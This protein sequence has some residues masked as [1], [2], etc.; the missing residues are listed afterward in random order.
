MGSNGE[1]TL[2]PAALEAFAAAI[3]SDRV[4]TSDEDIP[5]FRDP[6]WLATTR[7]TTR[8]RSS[9]RRRPRRSRRS[10]G[11]PTSTA[12]RSGRTRP[13]ATTATAGPRRASAAASSSRLRNMNRVL[14]IDDDLAYAVVEP[15]VRWFDLYDALQDGGH[16]L[17]V[18]IPDL[19]LGQRGR[20]LARQRRHLPEP[21]PGLP[22]GLRHGGRP[23]RRHRSCA[24]AWA[25]M[26]GNPAWHTYKRGLGPVLDPLF[27]QSNYGIVTRMGVW[28]QRRPEC[29]LPCRVPAV[30]RRGHRP[31]G[32]RSSAT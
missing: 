8:P 4:L 32:W 3:G 23:R 11:S 25:R 22:D 15:G 18:S 31:A 26:E 13:A 12:S 17:M 6:F 24:P 29:Y 30:A 5:E 27:M 10:S 21:R 9:C 16:D 28:L 14:E 20:Q 19:G 2:S 1:V 7:H